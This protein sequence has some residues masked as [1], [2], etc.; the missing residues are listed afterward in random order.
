VLP[1]RQTLLRLLRLEVGALLILLGPEIGEILRL[2]PNESCHAPVRS[3]FAPVLIAC[4][5]ATLA[6]VDEGHEV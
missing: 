2:L 5:A 1:R 3:K 6:L 4:I